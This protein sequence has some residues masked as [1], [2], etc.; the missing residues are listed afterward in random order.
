[1]DSYFALVKFHRI[2][3]QC[4]DRSDAMVSALTIE[5]ARNSYGSSIL[6][7]PPKKINN[8]NYKCD[9]RFH[10]DQILEMYDEKVNSVGIV[11]VSGREFKCYIVNIF[12]TAFECKLL[13][14]DTTYLQSQHKTG[15]Q[16]AVR[17]ERNRKIEKH[18]YEKKVMNNIMKS[19][20]SDNNTKYIIEG[21]IIAGPAELKN[22]IMDLDLFGQFFKSKLIDTIACDNIN[23]KTV[24]EV[25]EKASDKI[26]SYI[27]SNEYEILTEVNE[28]ITYASDK[29]LFGAEIFEN[30]KNCMVSKLIINKDMPKEEKN[31]IKE[32]ITYSCE[33]HEVPSYKIKMY[34]DMIGI[35]WF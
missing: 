7:F 1:M 25:Y 35:K 10:L 14:H 32:L 34:G 13:N 30:I 16:S 26:L 8:K 24:Y 4:A 12:G 15:G 5:P 22:T 29:L 18:E 6:I 17:M 20:L 9:S 23:D 19:Y 27:D 31:K 21:I 2:F 3:S 28:L 33:I 11:L